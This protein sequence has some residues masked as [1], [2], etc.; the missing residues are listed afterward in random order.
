MATSTIHATASLLSAESFT[1]SPHHVEQG[2]D[3]HPEEIDGV[4]VGRARLDHLVRASSRIGQLTDD[5]AEHD[6][7]EQQVDGVDAGEEEEVLHELAAGERVALTHQVHP[8]GDLEAEE[9]DAESGG[10]ER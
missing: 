4:P 7:P 3:D 5:D 10:D 1:P 6:E 8:L 2:E 9:R